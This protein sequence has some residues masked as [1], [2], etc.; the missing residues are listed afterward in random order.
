MSRYRAFVLLLT[1]V[2][3]SLLY[4]LA[5]GDTDII[6]RRGDVN[7]DRVVD[8]SDVVFLSSFLSNGAPAP[9]CLNRADANDDGMISGSD[10]VFLVVFLFN[11]G[12]PPPNPGPDNDYCIQDP[13]GDELGCED[14]SCL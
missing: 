3:S 12:A 2:P 1:F 5:G 4:A 10:P 6:G 13:T 7:N 11:A 8:V 9:S 14:S